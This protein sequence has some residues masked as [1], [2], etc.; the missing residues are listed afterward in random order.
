MRFSV[1][2]SGVVYKTFYT[3]DFAVGKIQRRSA[4]FFVVDLSSF[5]ILNH[6][7]VYGLSLF[8]P[9][10]NPEKLRETE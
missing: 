3:T 1:E 6:Y 9:G 10:L 5:S 2:A 8:Y 4:H 7:G